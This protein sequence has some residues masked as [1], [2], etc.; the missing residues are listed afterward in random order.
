MLQ[1][2][3]QYSSMPSISIH[4]LSDTSQLKA[5]LQAGMTVELREDDKILGR[6]VPQA[7]ASEPKEWPDFAARAEKIFGKRVLPGSELLIEDR[8]RY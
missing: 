6:I 4:E 8:G 2:V 3:K 5:W 1:I 7:P